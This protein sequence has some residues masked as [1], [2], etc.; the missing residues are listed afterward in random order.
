MPAE[1]KKKRRKNGLTVCTYVKVVYYYVGTYYMF[2]RN[3]GSEVLDMSWR[4][5]VK[6]TAGP[7]NKARP[8]MVTAIN[9]VP[10]IL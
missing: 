4:N 5:H 2:I 7:L 9:A 6:N 3:K 10:S 8:N 1:K